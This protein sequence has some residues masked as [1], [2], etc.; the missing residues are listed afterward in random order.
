[1]DFARYQPDQIMKYAFKLTLSA[2]RQIQKH[3]GAEILSVSATF[4]AKPRLC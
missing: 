2:K 1:M 4:R 3:A